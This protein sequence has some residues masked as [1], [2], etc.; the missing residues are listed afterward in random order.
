MISLDSSICFKWYSKVS[1]RIAI[2]CTMQNLT[3]IHAH[4]E[5]LCCLKV[6]VKSTEMMDFLK[7]WNV[8]FRW[9]LRTPNWCFWSSFLVLSHNATLLRRSSHRMVEE[10]YW[11]RRSG[12]TNHP[13]QMW[14]KWCFIWWYLL[15]PMLDSNDTQN[16]PREWIYLAACKA[17]LRSMHMVQR[18]FHAKFLWNDEFHE[19]MKYGLEM[20]SPHSKLMILRQ[21]RCAVAQCHI[22]S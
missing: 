7:S 4:G 21:F 18:Y 5:K 15:I 9:C 16:S 2:S 8:A 22:T 10:E 20:M 19:V 3:A 17:S 6:K 1:W 14:N 11:R 13:I 12:R